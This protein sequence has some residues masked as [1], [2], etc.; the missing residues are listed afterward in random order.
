MGFAGDTVPGKAASSKESKI[1]SR[2]VQEQNRKSA[3]T[4][5]IKTVIDEKNKTQN[6]EEESY[7]RLD[8]QYANVLKTQK[9]NMKVFE[10]ST[11]KNIYFT[12]ILLSC[13]TV[14]DKPIKFRL[15]PG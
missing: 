4:A 15:S 2:R 11:S 1:K 9:Q 14:V 8:W 3:F 6:L 10:S 7:P 5:K 12:S 13:S